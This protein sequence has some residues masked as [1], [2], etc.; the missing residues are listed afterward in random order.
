MIDILL[1]C[2]GPVG[3][4]LLAYVALF[5]WLDRAHG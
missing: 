1:W 5:A 3:L 2:G 4:V